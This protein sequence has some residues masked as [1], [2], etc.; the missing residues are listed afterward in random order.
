MKSTIAIAE[1]L[2]RL[3]VIEFLTCRGSSIGQYGDFSASH[4]TLRKMGFWQE[5]VPYTYFDGK[6]DRPHEYYLLKNHI[7]AETEACFLKGVQE[8]TGLRVYRHTGHLYAREFGVRVAIARN[9]R[10]REDM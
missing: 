3:D 9:N 5:T 8:R 2:Y 7:P 1:E 6:Q 4:E 10:L